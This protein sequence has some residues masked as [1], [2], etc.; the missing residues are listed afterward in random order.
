MIDI[1]RNDP[2]KGY[3]S[4]LGM[5]AKGELLLYTKPHKVH[6]MRPFP[7]T[8]SSGVEIFSTQQEADEWIKE[9]KS[10]YPPYPYGTSCKSTQQNGIVTV[11][12]SVFSAD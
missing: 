10:Y 2:H 1:T 11:E 5:T 9:L 3:S 6:D 8:N 12:Y 4:H 7:R